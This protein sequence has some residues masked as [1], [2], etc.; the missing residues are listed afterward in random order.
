MIRPVDGR[1]ELASTSMRWRR[2]DP[3]RSAPP[4][5]SIGPPGCRSSSASS[6]RERCRGH[7][8]RRS[9]RARVW[10][11]PSE[12]VE[13]A[14]RPR[15]RAPFLRFVGTETWPDGTI[16]SRYGFAH[17]LY[18]HAALARTSHVRLWHRASANGS[19]PDTAARPT[20]SHRSS[21]EHFDEGHAFCGRPL[22]AVAGERAA[23]RGGHGSYEAVGHFER[24]R[25][26]V[27]Q[28]LRRDRARRARA[29]LCAVLGPCLLADGGG[30]TRRG[31]HKRSR[32]L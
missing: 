24:A 6:S 23:R 29:A 12:T 20:P 11:C 7:V 17:A 2:V 3:T 14:A 27:S 13:R 19:R 26:L 21:A 10:R 28:L 5:C 15:E 30:G 18:Q 25:A 4:R 1:W 8:R 9:R 16:Q 32:A 31:S 22:S